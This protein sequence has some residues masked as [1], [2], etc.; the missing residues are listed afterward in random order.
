M[1][2]VIA[3]AGKGGTGKT[4]VAALVI[5]HL[6]RLEQRP[7]LAIDADA[8]DNLGEGIGM[9]KE[10]SIAQVTD[11]F[12]KD[13]ASLP[14]GMTKEAYLEQRLHTVVTEGKDIDLL[15]M[16]HPEGAGCY[17]Y[18]NNVL[19]AQM[20]RLVSNYPYVVVDNEAGLEHVSRRTTRKVDTMLMVSDFSAKAIRAAS[21]I[22]E[23][24]EELE[25]EVG[26]MGLV[27]N[28]APGEAS[29][30]SE[31]VAE[32]GLPLWAVLPASREVAENDARGRSVF[33]LSDDDPLVAETGGLVERLFKQ[34][35]G[36]GS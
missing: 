8:N 29:Q 3:T 12:I 20:E 10:G 25:L 28:R 24:V 33:Q 13:R 14:E 31:A 23:V 1:G 15:V 6:L 35:G 7:I 19:R 27:I 16:G 5:R 2:H 4:T 9:K 30:L 26:R 18:I 11:A 22:R 36:D 21:R 32:S 34:Q 17:C